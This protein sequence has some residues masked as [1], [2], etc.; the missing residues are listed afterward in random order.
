MEYATFAL[1]G[2]AERWWTGTEVLLKEDLGENARI[3]WDKFKEVFNETYFPEVVSDR[4]AR[5]V[6]DL[7]QGS[8][9]VEEYT[10]K[11]IDLSRFAPPFNS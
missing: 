8:M 7:V 3:T 10:A 11:F 5:E 1:E 6:F 4:K 9:T 2:P